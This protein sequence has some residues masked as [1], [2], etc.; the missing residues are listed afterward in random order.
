MVVDCRCGRAM[1]Q[2]KWRLVGV[3]GKV[4]VGWCEGEVEVGWCEGEAGL[5]GVRGK[6]R[7]WCV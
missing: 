1:G 3:R 2:G 7:Y 5:I 4:E 6:E